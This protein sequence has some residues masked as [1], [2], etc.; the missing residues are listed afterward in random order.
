VNT[1]NV[2]LFPFNEYWWFYGAFTVLVLVLVTVDLGVFHRKA[3]MISAREALMSTLAWVTLAGIFNFAFYKY[4]L[5]KFATDPRLQAIPGFDAAR[6]AKEAA[7]EFLSGYVVE[8]TLSVDNMFV[9]VLVFAYFR[10]PP[11]YQHRVL[12][13]GIMGAIIF[14][15]IFIALGSLLLGYTWV[16][17]LFGGFL[18]FTGIK[19]FFASDDDQPDL[20]NNPLLALVRK[21][22]PVTAQLYGPKFFIQD[23]GKRA[24]TPLFLTLVLMEASDIVFAVDSVPAIF[25]LTR[26][27]L[28]VFTSNIFAILGLRSM[29]FLLAG[30]VHRFHLLRYG[31]A[32]IL[33]F[34]G[35]KMAWLNQLYDGHF[36]TGISLGIIGGVLGTSIALSLAFPKKPPIS[37]GA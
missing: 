14:R 10:I 36:P 15:S 12:F 26:E 7:L 35:L 24:A 5:W 23:Q 20:E 21:V 33:T 16:I 30:A 13:Y 2:V 11:Q 29:Y 27:P 37:T 19:M 9:F 4:A 31:L 6:E 1:Q 8:E 28:I 34:I 17:W 25:A 32:I 3:H 18:V 22:M